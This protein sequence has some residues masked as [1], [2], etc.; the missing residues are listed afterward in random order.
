MALPSKTS[1][2][3][4]FIMEGNRS[5]CLMETL[6]LT[7]PPRYYK[8]HWT[9]QK[10]HSAFPDSDAWKLLRVP[11]NFWES[12]YSFRAWK[13]CV[14]FQITSPKVSQPALTGEF[15]ELLSKRSCFRLEKISKYLLIFPKEIQDH[16]TH[17]SENVMLKKSFPKYFP[18][19]VLRKRNGRTVPLNSVYYLVHLMIHTVV[20]KIMWCY[21]SHKKA[22]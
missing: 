3:L 12:I 20:V 8:I 10:E 19:K 16:L 13:H 15:C 2:F 21:K 4:P 9:G 22:G 7:F 1:L 14:F 5:S 11:E 18:Q 17:I 6:A